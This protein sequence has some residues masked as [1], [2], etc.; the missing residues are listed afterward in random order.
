MPSAGPLLLLLGLGG[1]AVG[2]AEGNPV[3]SILGLLSILIGLVAA[4]SDFTGGRS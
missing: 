2:G 4:I 3:V 1:L